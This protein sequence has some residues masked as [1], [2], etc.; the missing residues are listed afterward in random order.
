MPIK[1]VRVFYAEVPLDPEV[2]RATIEANKRKAAE[3]GGLIAGKA[4]LYK[5]QCVPGFKLGKTF[6][7]IF[8]FLIFK[9]TN[10]FSR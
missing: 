1:R 8:S 5:D 4:V 2:A 9:F 10:I 6:L 3:T 7:F